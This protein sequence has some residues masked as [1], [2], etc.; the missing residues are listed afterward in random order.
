MM[1]DLDPQAHATLGLGHEP[2]NLDRTIYHSIAAKQIEISRVILTTSIEGLDLAPS[3]I[4]LAKA[5]QELISV[6]RK[7]FILVD[8]LQSVSNKYDICVI[9]CPPSLGLLTFNAL[10]ASTDVLV[11]VQVHYYALE[12]LKQ[13][14]ETVKTARKR[15]YPCSVKILGLLL[16]FVED[17]SALSQQVEE[18]MRQFFGELVFDTVIHR[19]L[20]LAE[21]PSAGQCILAYD[22][23]SKGAAEYGALAEEVTDPDYKKKRKLPRE[24]SAIVDVAQAAEKAGAVQP[25][26]T[27][28]I[29]SKIQSVV[30]KPLERIPPFAEE[31]PER[32]AAVVEEPPERAEAAAEEIPER[33]EIVAEEAVEW[34]QRTDVWPTTGRRKLVFLSTFSILMV[35]VVVVLMFIMNMANTRPQAGSGSATVQEDVPTPITLIGS[36][37]DKDQLIYRIVTNPSHGHLTGPGPTMTYT[38]EPD[39]SGPDSFVFIVNDGAADSNEATV[40]LTVKAVN[41]AP[42]ADHKSVR[43]KVDR[44][45]SISL[46]GNDIDSDVLEYVICTEPKYGTLSFGSNFETNGKLVYTPRERFTG[47]DSFTFKLNDGVA[48]GAPAM[49]SI[50][51]TPNHA[52]MAELQTVTTAEDTPAAVNLQGSDPDG[53]T[54]IYSIVTGP[55]HGALSGKAPNLTYTPNNNFS[56]PDSF[57]FKVND[58]TTDSV[59]TTVS[60]LMTPAND[61]P[62]ATAANVTLLEDTSTPIVLAGIDPDGNQ[63]LTYSI[64]TGPSYGSLSGTEPNM[65]YTPD[66]NFSGSDGFTFK[67]NDGVSDSAPA[68]VSI[69]VAPVDDPPVAVASNVTLDEDTAAAIM[70]TGKD[71]DGD[72]LKYTVLRNPLH[73]K[74]SGEAPALTYTPD[75]NFSWLDS[76]TFKVNDGTSDSDAVTVM[77][78]VTPVNDPPRANDDIIVTQEDVEATID[79]LANDIE[80]DNELLTITAVSKPEGGSVTINS[81]GTLTYTPEANFYGRDS[82]TYTVTDREGETD[83]AT[84]EISLTST[85]DAPII[86]ST[87]PEIAMVGIQ[88]IYDVNATDPD[89]E[90]I[91]TYSLTN[92]PAGMTIDQATGLIRWTPKQAQDEA[93]DVTVK[94]VDSNSVPVA[95]IQRFRVNVNPTPPTS[96][97][98]TV[99]DGYNKN[100]KKKLS[101]EGKLDTVT[102]SDDK[103]LEAS[104]GSSIFYDFSDIT[105]PPGASV[106]SVTLYVEHFEEEQFADGKLKWEI[107][108]GWPAKPTVWYPLKAPVRIGKRNETTDAWDIT[109]FANTNAK[110]NALQLQIVNLRDSRKKTFVDCIH[111]VVRWK[112]PAPQ[113]TVQAK[114]GELQLFR[115]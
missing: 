42:T 90:D 34:T 108:K 78:S 31:I 74:L 17:Q 36:D 100:T 6:D 32:A 84:V 91:L 75:P 85:N 96:A 46:T 39:Y 45:A 73:G 47:S 57:T 94:V 72:V 53:D 70:L 113:E 50:N 21:A 112:W 95:G 9:D 69:M 43:I 23:D 66:P 2:D 37:P 86:T 56:G 87:P 88:Y 61:P 29:L 98:L 54:L 52:P 76:F 13:L 7:E 25:S 33:D 5:E 38:P 14:L 80:V 26:A 115:P 97:T 10:V 49:V 71:L 83:T 8:Q 27:E 20:S 77:I 68:V 111:A 67:A 19:T 28:D 102:A 63:Q 40:S 15:F 60:I 103:R 99:L 89:G 79:V 51:V 64:V 81:A 1:V 4:M 82:F 22:P 114:E 12:G 11:P 24:V 105:I 16:T 65:T 93:Y 35:V 109:S 41:D 58:G 44:S 30:E 104:Y 62:I 55:T 59:V 18:Q 101:A 92:Q 3:N 48:D 106:A 107:G 110:I